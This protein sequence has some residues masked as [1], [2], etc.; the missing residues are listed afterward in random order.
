MDVQQPARMKFE[1]EVSKKLFLLTTLQ[2]SSPD[3]SKLP[4]NDV[5]GV[6]A[7]LLTCSYNN[8]QN[9]S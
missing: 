7:I 5:V 1:L 8:D 6:T 4:S 9:V 3:I 2:G